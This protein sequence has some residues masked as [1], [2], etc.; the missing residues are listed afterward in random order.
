MA[1][2]QRPPRPDPAPYVRDEAVHFLPGDT[3]YT[4]DLDEA[5]VEALER[6]VCPEDLS[7][8]MHD[9]LRWRRDAIRA[10]TPPRLRRRSTDE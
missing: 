3:C 1:K 10:T 6:G 9:L 2:A 5:T 4:I 7:D 8:R